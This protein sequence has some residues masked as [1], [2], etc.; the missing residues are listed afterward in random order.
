MLLEIFHVS[1]TVIRINYTLT[2]LFCKHF[3]FSA[4]LNLQW[5]F[6]LFITCLGA[7]LRV[8]KLRSVVPFFIATLN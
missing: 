1:R 3:S 4:S 6:Q 8:I 2:F 5:L 7:S